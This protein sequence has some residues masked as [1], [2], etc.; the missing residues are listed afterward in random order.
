MKMFINKSKVLFL[1]AII[2]NATIT[3]QNYNPAKTDAD[4]VLIKAYE[5]L[6]LT[7][8]ELKDVNLNLKLL[9]SGNEDKLKASEQSKLNLSNEILTLQLFLKEQSE[10]I[11]QCSN[12]NKNLNIE[13]KNLKISLEQNADEYK[14]TL[15]EQQIKIQNLSKQI[16]G[17][18][19]EKI[20]I[21]EQY[22]LQKTENI[23]FQEKIQQLCQS[24]QKKE[25]EIQQLYQLVQK[26]EQEIKNLSTW[27]QQCLQRISTLDANILELQNAIKNMKNSN[28]K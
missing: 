17:L 7:N 11:A 28:K 24:T 26:K 13:N 15:S 4:K 20:K 9:L 21:L 5:N 3:M 10:N 23:R 1:G 2:F 8:A 27:N 25:Q 19:E 14:M 12:A 6:L 18:A 16:K 22:K